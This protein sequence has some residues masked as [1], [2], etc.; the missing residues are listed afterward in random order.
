MKLLKNCGKNGKSM[1]FFRSDWLEKVRLQNGEFVLQPY[2]PSI[3]NIIALRVK[4]KGLVVFVRTS[5]ERSTVRTN[6]TSHPPMW[7]TRG[8]LRLILNERREMEYYRKGYCT[9][10]DA[11][12]IRR[13]DIK[14]P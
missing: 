10:S 3:P 13:Q 9:F 11:T 14:T 5:N 8:I 4:T 7:P 2:N 6:P 12:E 1:L